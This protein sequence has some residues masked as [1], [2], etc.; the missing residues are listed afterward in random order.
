MAAD[1]ADAVAV[2]AVVL[3]V[4]PYTK[5]KFATQESASADGCA[6]FVSGPC[7]SR[8][9]LPANIMLII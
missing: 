2:E 3:G 1:R 9:R 5:V 7:S 6:L 4:S 8:N